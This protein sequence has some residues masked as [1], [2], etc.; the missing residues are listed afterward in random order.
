MILTTIETRRSLA[1]YAEREVDPDLALFQ[2][3]LTLDQMKHVPQSSL[4]WDFF[5][6]FD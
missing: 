3:D 1:L 4:T 2:I 6:A 5:L